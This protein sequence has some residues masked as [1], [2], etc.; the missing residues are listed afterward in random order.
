[1]WVLHFP[2]RQR[3]FECLLALILRLGIEIRQLGLLFDLAV[4]LDVFGTV[5]LGGVLGFKKTRMDASEAGD[6]LLARVLVL[7]NDKHLFLGLPVCG[8]SDAKS[9][10]K[11]KMTSIISKVE[12]SLLACVA[13]Q[14]HAI[15]LKFGGQYDGPVGKLASD[16]MNKVRDAIDGM[17]RDLERAVEM[18]QSERAKE[19]VAKIKK[20]SAAAKKT[21]KTAKKTKSKK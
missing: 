15:F 7:D 13:K 10:S 14:E 8:F 20:P 3:L 2:F 11:S 16:A 9:K 19:R 12:N 17:Y 1:M 6:V 18:K 4:L 21:K 5:L